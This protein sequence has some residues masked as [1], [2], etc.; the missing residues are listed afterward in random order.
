MY[1]LALFIISKLCFLLTG[2]VTVNVTDLD[3]HT[4]MVPVQLQ[5]CTAFYFES[6]A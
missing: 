4:V 2:Y 1:L 3:E 5:Y 6:W